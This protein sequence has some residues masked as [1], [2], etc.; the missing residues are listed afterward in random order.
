VEQKDG[1]LSIE[2]REVQLN[3]GLT[4][5]AVR[6]SSAGAPLPLFATP[7]SVNAPIILEPTTQLLAAYSQTAPA[8]LIGLSGPPPNWGG[9][10][11]F[12]STDD[13]TYGYLGTQN[14]STPM[15]VLVNDLPAFSGPNPDLTDT[16]TVDLSESDGELMSWNP[17]DAANGVSLFAIVNPS[18]GVEY[19]AYTNA[20]LIGPNQYQLTT[21][22]RGLY[23]TSGNF[24]PAGSQFM[25]LGSEQFFSTTLAAQY[26]GQ[27]LWFKFTSFNTFGYNLQDLAD[28][29]AYEY[30]P[31]GSGSTIR[32]VQ[33]TSQII[34]ESEGTI[35]VSVTTQMVMESLNTVGAV[36]NFP[37]ENAI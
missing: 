31:T 2:C 34:M 36:F 21:L 33:R 28:V 17:V 24:A 35:A 7:P 13:V 9:A 15:G 8:L 26:I 14:G 20:T 1:R 12:I 30:F 19:G 18:G 32:G 22:Y 27:P 37:L 4:S 25:F 10:Q 5:G 29:V 11:I 3:A 6:Q 16:L 23:G